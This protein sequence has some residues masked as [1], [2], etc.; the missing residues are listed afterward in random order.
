MTN[1]E[2]ERYMLVEGVSTNPVQ[3]DGSKVL[4]F[5]CTGEG[6]KVHINQMITSYC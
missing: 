4:K 3:I 5:H 2:S 1:E 6:R